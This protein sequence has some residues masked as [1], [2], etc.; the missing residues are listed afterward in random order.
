MRFIIKAVS[1]TGLEMWISRERFG[2]RTFG[3]REKAEVF[4]TRT[5]AQTGADKASQS[6]K[7]LDMRFTVEAAD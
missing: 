2:N 5:E 3:P 6:F 1:S 7:D 4:R